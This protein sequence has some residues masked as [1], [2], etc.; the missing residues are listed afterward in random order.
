MKIGYNEATAKDC[1]TLEKD[2]ELCEKYGFDYIEIRLDMLKDYLKTHTSDDLKK[3]FETSHI[4]PHAMNALYIYEDLFSEKDDS[5]KHK[6]VMDDFL[7]GCETAQEIGSEY[8]VVVAP[9]NRNPA[10]GPYIG[11]WPSIFNNCVRILKELADIAEGYG[12]KLC[13]ELVGSKYCSVRTVDQAWEIVKTVNK[14]NVGLVFDVFNLYLFNKLEDFS[15]MEMVD[16]EKIYAIHINN[17]DDAAMEELTQANRRF[18]DT[19]E[20]NLENFFHVLQR[21]N[22]DGMVSI[23]TFR[24]EYWNKASDWVIQHA[25]ETTLKT[26]KQFKAII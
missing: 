10:E 16:P 25:Y 1:S 15:V 6:E 20:I 5:I 3:F 24:P 26:L 22:Y 7:L 21:M 18:C 23:E 11:E 14:N 13:F 19:G 9:L 17:A 8:F 2:L 4:K 12:V